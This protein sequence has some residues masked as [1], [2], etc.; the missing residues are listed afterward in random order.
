[1]GY[2]NDLRLWASVLNRTKQHMNVHTTGQVLNIIPSIFLLALLV[3]RVQAGGQET[4][5]QVLRKTLSSAGKR[6]CST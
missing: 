6:N 3:R 1:M 5:H 2:V 4:L